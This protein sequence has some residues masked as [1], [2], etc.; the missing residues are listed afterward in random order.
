MSRLLHHCGGVG[1]GRGEREG[2]DVPVSFP[3][4]VSKAFKAKTC[5]VMDLGPSMHQH[6]HTRTHTHSES[7]THSL[8]Q[9]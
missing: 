7:S 3:K 1:G 9:K 8:C 5:T 4:L 2:Y 6:T